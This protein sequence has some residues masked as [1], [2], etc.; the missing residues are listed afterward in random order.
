MVLII[1]KT[2]PSMG[3]RSRML[4]L[5]VSCYKVLSN[6]VGLGVKKA[7]C[8]GVCGASSP[9]SPR[10]FDSNTVLHATSQACCEF[11]LT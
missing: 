7:G 10:L 1:T 11:G 5:G 9:P 3:P 4:Q 6:A 8:C 2:I